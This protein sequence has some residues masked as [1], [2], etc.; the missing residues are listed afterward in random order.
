M[1]QYRP[2]DFFNRAPR[3]PG[4]PN[5]PVDP[6]DSPARHRQW[7]NSVPQP[8]PRLRPG[9]TFGYSNKEIITWSG[10]CRAAMAVW[11]TT[12]TSRARL[13]TTTRANDPTSIIRVPKNA[14]SG[15]T[16][17]LI[18][19]GTP[20]SC[21]RYQDGMCALGAGSDACTRVSRTRW[22][23][24]SA[25]TEMQRTINRCHDCIHDVGSHESSARDRE[26]RFRVRVK[27][28]WLGSGACLWRGRRVH[29]AKRLAALAGVARGSRSVPVL[30]P[31]HASPEPRVVRGSFVVKFGL[32][33]SCARYQDPRMACAR[34]LG[35]GSDACTRVS[36]HSVFI[37]EN[38]AFVVVCLE[39]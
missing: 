30:V 7:R 18:L 6:G 39:T 21:A 11:S 4:R 17:R 34:W 32:P 38:E 36:A 33:R 28:I 29:G 10:A 26:L 19:R 31:V 23:A 20:R 5:P 27:P 25:Q 22:L 3:R 14:F 35:A 15:H 37:N 24:K 9:G 12:Q 2:Q 8:V 16:L 13:T 1:T